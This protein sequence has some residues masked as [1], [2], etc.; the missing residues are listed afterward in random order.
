MM[1]GRGGLLLAASAASS[2]FDPAAWLAANAVAYWRME[3]AGVFQ[4][5]ATGRGNRLNHSNLFDDPA[6]A[7]GKVGQ[8]WDDPASHDFFARASNADLQVGAG[9][10]IVAA[11]VRPS[12]FP[13]VI[14][15]VSKWGFGS[16]EY[17]LGVSDDGSAYFNTTS[18]GTFGTL[19]GVSG[20]VVAA[21]QWALLVARYDSA[22]G[23]ISI[24]VNNGAVTEDDR[25]DGVHV[26]GADFILGTDSFNSVF[27][28]GLL[29]E[30][31]LAKPAAPLS[32]GDFD[33]LSSFLWN[34]G[35]GRDLT[36]LF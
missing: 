33:A 11:W 8:A 1:L 12:S 4:A 17:A 10:F 36:A 18:D 15:I 2:S 16:L 21:E 7:A 3:D 27:F 25:P 26:G 32:S 5:D 24:R 9:D 30:T 29:D 23:K 31:L 28:D 20:D 35:A 22:G 34:G 14:P 13:D 6:Y 19:V